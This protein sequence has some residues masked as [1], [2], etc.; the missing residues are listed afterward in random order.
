MSFQVQ[1]FPLGP[2][3]TNCYLVSRGGEAVVIDPGGDPDV[4]VRSIKQSKFKVTHILNTHLHFDHT[5]GNAALQREFGVDILSGAE[6]AV[7]LD[8]EL[9]QG[10]AYGLPKVESYQYKPLAPGTTSFLGTECQVLFTPGHT[11]GSLSFYFPAYG[12]VFTGDVLFR[13]S[14]GRT[15]FA[16]GSAKILR[17][18][19]RDVLF[20]LPDETTAWPGHGEETNIGDEKVNNPYYGQFARI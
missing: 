15:D 11:P 8:S 7:L 1:R 2:L 9:G 14:V 18:S 6:D 13:R 5:Y 4:L 19:I 20:K 10:G 12:H 17:D 3:D 16:G